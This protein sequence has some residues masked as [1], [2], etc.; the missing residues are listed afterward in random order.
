MTQSHDLIVHLLRGFYWLDDSLQA[1]LA[2]RGWPPVSRSQSMILSNLAAG[3][4]RPAHIAAN[5][6]LSRQLVHH[7]LKQLIDLGV[8]RLAPDPEDGRSKIVVHGPKGGLVRDAVEILQALERELAKR[9]GVRDL[10]A[11]E[12]L[13]AAD[14]GPTAV[15]PRR[16][17]RRSARSAGGLA[18][19][20]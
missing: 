3:V 11:A 20:R 9:L 6:G 2:A 13:L 4:N 16:G 14:W 15:V 19:S 5:L 12:R 17:Q 1:S 10:R 7:H 18:R 8:L